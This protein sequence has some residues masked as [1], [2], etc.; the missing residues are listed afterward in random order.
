MDSEAYGF[1]AYPQCPLKDA[2]LNY[3]CI[4]VCLMYEEMHPFNTFAYCIKKYM[5]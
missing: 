2:F 5:P 1:S 4:E 3:K